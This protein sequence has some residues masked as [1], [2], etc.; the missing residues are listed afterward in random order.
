MDPAK[1][2]VVDLRQELQARGLDT[3]GVKV[4]LVKRLKDALEQESKESEKQAVDETVLDENVGESRN[5]IKSEKSPVKTPIKEESGTQ[6]IA[7]KSPSPVKVG[8]KD[9]CEDEEMSGEE[10]FPENPKVI[11]EK[12]P[13]AVSD[14]VSDELVSDSKD[15]DG[16]PEENGDHTA[17]SKIREPHEES[18]SEESNTQTVSTNDTVAQIGNGKRKR[19]DDSFEEEE[20]RVKKPREKTY[21]PVTI[22]EDEPDIKYE[23]VQI[24]WIDSDLHLQIDKESFLSA[25]PLNDGCFGF[26]WAGARATYGINS[27][28]VCFE[29]K[30]TEE[31]K[32]ED[33]SKYMQDRRDRDRGRY[34]SGK[35]QYQLKESNKTTEN[36]HVNKEDEPNKPTENESA[37]KQDESTNKDEAERTEK[38]NDGTENS[39]NANKT[40]ESNSEDT[41]KIAESENM[42]TD[43]N[44]QVQAENV[45]ENEDTSNNQEITDNTVAEETKESTGSNED[46]PSTEQVV[47]EPIPIYYFRVGFSLPK[48]TLQLG[49]SIYSYAYESTGRF[50]TDKQ[51]QDYGTTFGVGDVIG[52]YLAIDDQQVTITYTVNGVSQSAITVPRSEITLEELTLFPHILC[53]NYAYEVNFGNREEPWFPHP[54]ELKDYNFLQSAPNKVLGVKSLEKRSDCELI[55]MIGLPGSGKTHW[56]QQHLESSSDKVYYV[57]GN[58]A[59]F[60]RMTVDGQPFKSRFRGSWKV[61]VDQLQKCFN[62]I[63]EISSTRRRNFIIDQ[64]SN[65]F[66]QSQ[67]RKLRLFEGF[68]RRA[69]CLVCNEEELSRRH[70]QKEAEQG[71]VI[72]QSTLIDHKG[73]MHI[74]EDFTDLEFI[75]PELNEEEA[76]N[77]IKKYHEEYQK[78][79]YNKKGFNNR[80]DNRRNYYPQNNYRDR[81]AG[82]RYDRYSSGGWGGRPGGGWNRDR[83]DSRNLQPP[84]DSGWRPQPSRNPA[85][86]SRNSYG[87]GWGGGGQSQ[88]WNQQ[89]FGSHGYGAWSQN[90]QGWRYSGQ[91]GYGGSGGQ[92]NARHGQQGWNYYGQ[93]NQH[94]GWGSQQGR[95]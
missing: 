59:M 3:K 80:R 90:Q 14:K 26:I 93:Y 10:S 27:G 57:I 29:V 68:K 33:P 88:G 37:N 56:I 74:P 7:L 63:T 9:E 44:K 42:E 64:Q 84:A 52:A 53:R 43:E 31:L 1:L 67:I 40:A 82:G 19:H 92:G 75:Y 22:K 4:T 36:K 18:K 5:N 61:L 28:K 71:K 50:I 76:K 66:R 38:S 78:K 60:E 8:L 49:E 17:E 55:L 85:Y 46:K 11:S 12:L 87:G 20:R 6:K 48:S 69:V 54:D 35:Q 39:E 65:V 2:K 30:I 41:N 45:A 86:A 77:L 83:R 16:K 32:W 89:V 79:G 95:K 91:G 62:K 24:S 94:Q 51:F 25:K 13:E 47:K 34:K 70:K 23:N 21:E 73:Q 72:P 58:D 81:F 15:E